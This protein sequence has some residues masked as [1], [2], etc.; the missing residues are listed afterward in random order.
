[1]IVEITMRTNYLAPNYSIILLQATDAVDFVFLPQKGISH[2][3]FFEDYVK[4]SI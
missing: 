2:T 3:V 4:V 1:M